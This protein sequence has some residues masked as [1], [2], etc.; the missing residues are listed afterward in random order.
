[1]D[2]IDG[3]YTGFCFSVVDNKFE[4]LALST[5][6]EAS[7]VHKLLM[8]GSQYLAGDFI[9]AFLLVKT[10]GGRI[11]LALKYEN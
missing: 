10:A 2:W 1:M 11:L 3:I 7:V 8:E 6:N 4:L 9:T 5:T